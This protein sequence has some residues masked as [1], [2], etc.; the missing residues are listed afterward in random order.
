MSL[1]KMI[2]EEEA[3]GKVK[4]IYEEIRSSLGIDFIQIYTR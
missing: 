1:V 4:E 3:Q 2:S